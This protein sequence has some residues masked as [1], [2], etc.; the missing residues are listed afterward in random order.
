MSSGPGLDPGL[1][2]RGDEPVV[3]ERSGR[4][5]GGPEQLVESL[6]GAPQPSRPGQF[7]TIGRHAGQAREA[8]GDGVAIVQVLSELEALLQQRHRAFARSLVDR[9]EPESGES[10]S[11]V[12]YQPDLPGQGQALLIQR[13]GLPGVA[14]A[15]GQGAEVEEGQGDPALL[16]KRPPQ[17]E[18]L[19]QHRSGARGIT[20]E[21]P[22]GLG[23]VFQAVLAEVALD[24]LGRQIDPDQL[25]GRLR[26][27]YLAA[28][29]RGADARGPVQIDADVPLDCSRRL[30]AVDPHA[31]SQWHVLRPCVAGERALRGHRRRDGVPGG[32]KGREVGVALVV[33]LLTSVTGDRLPQQ[34]AMLA[35]DRSRR[36]ARMIKRRDAESSAAG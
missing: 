19:L 3:M 6:G 32:R 8:L 1:L 27:E 13:H 24:R 28:V 12:W 22:L 16:S 25:T 9:G 35:P 33:D 5:W 2:S 17:R 15:Q 14:F 21:Q 4:R 26:D 11:R 30:A 23:E 34:P 7:R 29:R 10:P 20:L 31:Y 18:A 36:I